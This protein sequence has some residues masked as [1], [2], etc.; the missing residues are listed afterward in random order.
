[1]LGIHLSKKYSLHAEHD[2][3]ISI[4]MDNHSLL[5]KISKSIFG[6]L[7][8]I[9]YRTLHI[10][11]KNIEI[12]ISVANYIQQRLGWWQDNPTKDMLVIN[13]IQT[14]LGLYCAWI[15]ETI[16]PGCIGSDRQP[17]FEIVLI[18]I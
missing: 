6:E 4:H 3:R 2:H 17:R 7:S 11:A 10:I 14:G 18:G 5:S 1:M 15:V 9:V 13:Q 12:I 16:V 8:W